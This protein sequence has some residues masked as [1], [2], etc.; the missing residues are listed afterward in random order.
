MIIKILLGWLVLC[1]IATYA[2]YLFWSRIKA[3]EKPPK[4]KPNAK[5]NRVTYINGE[6][7]R[8]V[9]FYRGDL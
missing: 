9:T 1:A 4:K 3:I 7:G 8:Q 5:L 2:N 6:T